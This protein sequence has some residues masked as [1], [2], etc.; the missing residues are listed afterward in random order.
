MAARRDSEE[1]HTDRAL[2]RRDWEIR[3]LLWRVAETEVLRMCWS[4]EGSIS[5]W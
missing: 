3:E 1:I 2:T 5:L 4:V